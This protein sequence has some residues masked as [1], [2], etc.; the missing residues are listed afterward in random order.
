MTNAI[1]SNQQNKIK[2]I[3]TTAIWRSKH[4]S[5]H[6]SSSDRFYVALLPARKTTITLLLKM[7]LLCGIE[8]LPRMESTYYNNYALNACALALNS[9]AVLIVGLIEAIDFSASYPW[10]KDGLIPNTATAIYNFETKSWSLQEPIDY[11]TGWNKPQ[12]F[13]YIYSYTCQ[14]I[15]DKKWNRYKYKI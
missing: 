14:I 11:N 10:D 9:S 12:P 4:H 1:L 8:L 3:E 15:P 6:L 5:T 2:L 13:E 7:D